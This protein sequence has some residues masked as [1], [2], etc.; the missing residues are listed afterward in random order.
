MNLLLLDYVYFE[1]SKGFTENF[2]WTDIFVNTLGLPIY[3]PK[4]C[5]I[6]ICGLLDQLML[7]VELSCFVDWSRSSESRSVTWIY[8]LLEM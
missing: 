8:Q 5:R 2:P 6:E 1:Q 3:Y 4:T 7:F